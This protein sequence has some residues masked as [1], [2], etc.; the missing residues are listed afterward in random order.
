[1]AKCPKSMVEAWRDCL[2]CVHCDEFED[3]QEC[4][5]CFDDPAH[6]DWEMKDDEDII[7]GE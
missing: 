5:D 2:D 3:R 4:M 7:E 1:M 6:P